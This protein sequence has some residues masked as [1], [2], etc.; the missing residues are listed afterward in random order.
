M[1]NLLMAIT[2]LIGFVVFAALVIFGAGVTLYFIVS[3]F[4]DVFKDGDDEKWD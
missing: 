4:H 1:V 2:D 3:F